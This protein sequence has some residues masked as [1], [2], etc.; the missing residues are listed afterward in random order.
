MKKEGKTNANYRVRKGK[1]T[2]SKTTKKFKTMP[3]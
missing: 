1:Y 2:V 3:L